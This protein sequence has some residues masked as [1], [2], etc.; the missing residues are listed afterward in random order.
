MELTQAG[1][2]DMLFPMV[3]ESPI[4]VVR[5][6]KA[7]RHH[8]LGQFC[9]PPLHR[10]IKIEVLRYA[11]GIRRDVFPHACNILGHAPHWSNIGGP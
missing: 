5:V 4:Y 9:A 10:M 11:E 2:A 3:G 7:W 8:W 1:A 6:A